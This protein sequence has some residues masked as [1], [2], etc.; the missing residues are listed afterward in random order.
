MSHQHSQAQTVGNRILQRRMAMGYTAAELG[1][2]AKISKAYLSAIEHDHATTPSADLLYRIAD[3]L[4]TTMP[5]L[6]GLPEQGGPPVAPPTPFQ[7]AVAQARDTL[8]SPSSTYDD[9]HI[10]QLRF[11]LDYV[12]TALEHLPENRRAN[13]GK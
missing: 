9:Q 8:D 1:R 11:V 4:R 12:I 13:G 6:L 7:E 2:R 10:V 3:A 5:S